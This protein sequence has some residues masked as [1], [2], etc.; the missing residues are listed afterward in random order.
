MSRFQLGRRALVVGLIGGLAGAGCAGLD[1]VGN[2]TGTMVLGFGTYSV[3]VTI[4]AAEVMGGPIVLD[5]DVTFGAS[6]FTGDGEPDERVMEPRFR[7]DVAAVD[8]TY[9]RVLPGTAFSGTLQPK[10]PGSTEIHFSLYD[11][12]ISGYS[13]TA[14]VPITVN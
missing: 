14:V 9:V 5:A 6:F 3:T 4:P 7:L 11:S 8:T 2:G 1:D 10:A 12:D 13:F